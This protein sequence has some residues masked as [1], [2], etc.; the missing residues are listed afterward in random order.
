M[1]VA[2]GMFFFA[3]AKMDGEHAFVGSCEARFSPKGGVAD[4]IVEKVDKANASIYIALFS[5]GSKPIYNALL[6][7]K[8]RGVKVYVIA[9]FKQSK[10][11]YSLIPQCEK[12]FDR[13][14]LGP[15]RVTFHHKYAVFD[16]KA[17]I[18]G[19]ANWSKN[20]DV[21][22]RENIVYIEDVY[23]VD[24]YLKKWKGYVENGDVDRYGV[25]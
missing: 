18:T 20:A 4:L 14:Y 9:D 19:S 5:F 17:V 2:G 11:C 10:G 15:S 23:I 8:K 1:G 24:M 6:R 3:G 12:D 22:N 25:L 16:E 21:A 7:A 13:V